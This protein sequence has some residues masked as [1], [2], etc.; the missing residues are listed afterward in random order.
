[1]KIVSDF[2]HRIRHIEHLWITMPDGIRLA[3]R[4]WMPESAE[5]SPVPAIL[6]YIP[7]RKRDGVRL[8]DETMH[9]YFAGHGYA[10]IRVDIRGSGDSEGVLCDEYLQQELND[11]VAVIK[12]LVQ[13]SWCNGNVGMIGISWGGFN[14]LQIAAMQPPALKAVVSVCSTDD[15]YADD[16]HYMGGCL[17]GDNLSW[18]STMFAYNSLPPDP[19]IVGG[20]WRDM[21]FERLQGSGLWLEIW[22]QHQH[23]GE[24]W[25]HGSI[26]EDYS[27][28][29]IP[30][31]AVSGWADGY[32]NAV[33]RLLANLSGPRLGLIGPWSHKYPH[34]GVPGPAIGFLQECLRWWDKWLKNQETDI[35]GEPMLRA[36]MLDSMPPST[37]YHQR[38]GRWISESCWPSPNI[39]PR[40][41][42]LDEYRLVDEDNNVA[43]HALT[44][45]SPLSNGLFAGKWCSYS[46]TPD[47]PH[48]QR[49]EDGGALLFTTTP[50]LETLEIL[51]APVLELELSANRPVA[52]IAVRLS[53]MRPDNK[54][55]RI[56]YGMLNLTHRDSHADP[57]SLQPDKVYPVRVQL[58]DVAQSLPKGH[59][60]RIAISSSY[61]PLAWPPPQSAQ[62]KIHIGSSRLILPVRTPREEYI[63][64]PDAEASVSSQQRQIKEGHHNWRVIRE[65]DQD[66]ST[67]EVINDNGL[68][69]LEDIDL[70]VQRKTEEWYS[71]QGD[72]FSSAKGA[73]LWTR[74]FER[75]DWQIKTITRTVLRCDENYFYLDAELDAYEAGKRVFSKNW[76]RRIR[77][78]LV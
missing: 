22:L 41:Y 23:R 14:G 20:R 9:P 59:R 54:V 78:K 34:L 35:M 16:V 4:I 43:A 37:F 61:F 72:D 39:M 32:S 60:I 17:L 47:L 68:Y 64:F 24:Y 40:I 13:Q 6:E 36:W 75:G 69:Q 44:L 51:G 50:L 33:F 21:W 2:P 45:Q 48:D 26:C 5:A 52:M 7:Y 76:N 56:T 19:A 12:W 1:M 29:N 63:N 53:D 27:K 73:T 3:A 74:S 57:S 42:K 28:V 10:C 71:Y 15:R 77:R 30:V 65:L 8:R 70:K 66:I 49:E 11:G 58:N 55:T 46:A 62:L 18:A 38:Y 31:M 67:L 25:R